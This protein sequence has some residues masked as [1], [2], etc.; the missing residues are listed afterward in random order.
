M[1]NFLRNTLFFGN[2][3]H[4]THKKVSTGPKPKERVSY[5]FRLLTPSSFTQRRVRPGRPG[6]PT[7]RRP[8]RRLPR[9]TRR[10]V[11][12]PATRSPRLL[13]VDAETTGAAPVRRK[14]IF[15]LRGKALPGSRKT[16]LLSHHYHCQQTHTTTKPKLKTSLTSNLKVLKSVLEDSVG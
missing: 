1:V 2:S 10:L 5:G 8:R 9:H 12:R 3:V 4:M 13:P 11:C 16:N 14:E 6:T 7:R 15:P